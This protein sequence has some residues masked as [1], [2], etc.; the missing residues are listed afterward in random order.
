MSRIRDYLARRCERPVRVR[1]FIHG[2]VG[3]GR[4]LKIIVSWRKRENDGEA[5]SK[6][7]DPGKIRAVQRC[8]N[9]G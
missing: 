1:L 5:V 7:T 6:P 8:G 3:N 4:T 2:G 9:T